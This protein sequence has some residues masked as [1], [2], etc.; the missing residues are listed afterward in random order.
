[1]LEWNAPAI[2]FYQ[3]LGARPMSGWTHYRWY[4]G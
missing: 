1:M 4:D 3:Q 2:D